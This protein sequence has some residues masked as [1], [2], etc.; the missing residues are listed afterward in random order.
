[1]LAGVL[2]CYDTFLEQNPLVWASHKLKVT[3]TLFKNDLLHKP[4]FRKTVLGGQPVSAIC[5]NVQST[6]RNGS[7]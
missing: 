5:N 4:S 2:R 7:T 1:L 3:N 6:P